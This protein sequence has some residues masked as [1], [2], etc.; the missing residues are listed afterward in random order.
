[1]SLKKQ[2]INDLRPKIQVNSPFL[3]KF[4][5]E[6]EA[7]DGRSY[8]SLILA[9]KSGEME[10]RKWNEASK[11][12]ESFKSGDIVLI[13][14]KVNLFQNRQQIIVQDILPLNQ[15]KLQREDYIFKAKTE[16]EIMFSQLIDL[17]NSLEEVYIRDLLLSLLHDNEIS[18]RL[19]TW[20]AGKTI[21]HAYESGL[22]EHIL[23]CSKLGV[24]LSDF[25]QV[26]KSYV[27]AGCILH[28]LCKV[29]ELTEGPNV[30]YT[31]EGKLVGHLVKGVELLEFYSTKIKN[32]PYPQKIHLKHILL[33]HHGEYEFGSPKIPQTKEAYLVHLIDLLDS[34][35]N[36]MDSAVRTDSQT[37]KWTNYIKHLDRVVYKQELPSYKNYI[38]SQKASTTQTPKGS[39]GKG[40]MAELLKDFKIT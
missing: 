30:E 9:D 10:G 19:K 17:V 2:F 14:G 22:L 24:F 36:A 16:A 8:L 1:M 12:A 33:S 25:Y 31:D 3:I 35:M 28:D 34:K 26:N 5:S 27:L 13:Q 29:Y 37:G 21:H 11:D 23:S 20:Q 32:F 40:K 7:R 18:R 15:E 38:D 39:E 4:I 6:V